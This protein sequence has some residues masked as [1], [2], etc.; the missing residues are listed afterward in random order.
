MI[1][2]APLV[3]ILAMVA[4]YAFAGEPERTPLQAMPPILA[5]PS[6]PSYEAE[7]IEGD[8]EQK[9]KKA[10]QFDGLEDFTRVESS[11]A[12]RLFGVERLDPIVGVTR[13]DRVDRPEK[14]D[15]PEKVERIEKIE[16]VEKVERRERVERVGRR[17]RK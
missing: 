4:G 17:G 10:R 2:A 9:K 16:K 6:G 1:T 8:P 14:I 15:R 5:S 7:L 13:P 3:L 11:P 12:E